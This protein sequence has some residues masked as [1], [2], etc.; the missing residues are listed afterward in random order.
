M[1]AEPEHP[2]M[3]S[4]DSSGRF[5]QRL[6]VGVALLNLIVAGLAWY[7]LERSRVRYN[8]RA[9]ITTQ[10]ISRI[11]DENLTGILARVDLALQ[12]VVDEAERQLAQGPIRTV[13]FNAFILREHARLPELAVLR[14]TDP[15][16]EAV[17]GPTA[18]AANSA[19]LAHRDYFKH[20]KATPSA[21]LVIS[22]PLIGG[23][24]GKWMVVLARRINGPDG[25]FAGLVYAGVTLDYLTQSFSRLDVGKLGS[26]TLIE[27]DGTLIA[28][29][30]EGPA[31]GVAVGQRIS[32]TKLNEMI[33]ANGTEGVYRSRSRVDSI[34]KT[35]SFRRLGGVHPFYVLVGLAT[36]EYLAEWRSE[37]WH[38]AA[39]IAVFLALT[40]ISTALI[41]REWQRAA[42]EAAERVR[43]QARLTR[44]KEALE[45]MLARTK[46][47]EGLIS[48]CM[49]CKKINNQQASWE[50]LE[51]YLSDHSDALF[52]HGICPDCLRTRYPDLGRPWK[53]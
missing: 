2:G 15:E 29:Y 27:P 9:A 36:P 41:A 26:I 19:S 1:T 45:A 46:R 43:A 10:N 39:F 37:A 21:G 5:I 11:L 4:P 7:S 12:S 42:R 14:A 13:P 22:E 48:I 3:S 28:R 47:L 6:V 38:L 52:S 17:F 51:K 24:S 49:H 8:E 23:I 34:E 16:G 40:G 20:L 32:S 25:A 53:D 33:R 50:Q 35:F 44:Q 18:R 31:A 30:P